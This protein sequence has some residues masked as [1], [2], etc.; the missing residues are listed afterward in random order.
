SAPYLRLVEFCCS[1]Q[2]LQKPARSKE[3]CEDQYRNRSRRLRC[4][5]ILTSLPFWMKRQAGRPC[6]VFIVQ[7][8]A[9]VPR[10]LI[11]PRERCIVIEV[12]QVAQRQ[13][14]SLCAGRFTA[15]DTHRGGRKRL[16]TIDIAEQI[17]QL[18]E[19][20]NT[21]QSGTGL[22]TDPKPFGVPGCVPAK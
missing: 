11:R 1:Q 3:R 20:F 19:G 8:S 16:G 17:L 7:C 15:D 10:I 21:H 12:I 4:S 2:A 6:S 14:D 18:R 13:C 5:S 9:S 22:G